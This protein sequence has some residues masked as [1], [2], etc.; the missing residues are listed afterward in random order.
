M[1]RRILV[2]EKWRWYTT[3]VLGP[4][5]GA[6]IST[7]IIRLAIPIGRLAPIGVAIVLVLAGCVAVAVS[8]ASSPVYRAIARREVSAVLGSSR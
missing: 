1:H 8:I 7:A 2:S 3:D 5:A 6:A 4:V